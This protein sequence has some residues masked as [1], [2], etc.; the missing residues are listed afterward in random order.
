LNWRKNL[1][2][3]WFGCLISNSSY[4]ML[5]PFLPL[6]L[7]DLGASGAMIN[8]WS[9]FILSAT[10]FVSAMMAPY[11]GKRADRAG[12]RKMLLRAGFSLGSVYILG[13]F[14]SSPLELFG[15]RILQGF[16]AGFVPAALAIVSSSMPEERMGW[17]L[18]IMQAAIL[19]GTIIGPLIG[20]IL[21]H[22]FGIRLSFIVAGCIML[23]GTF[24]V[25]M[26]VTEPLAAGSKQTDSVANDVKVALNNRLFIWM[27]VLLSFS[28]MV[29]M[30]LQPITPLYIAE[31]Q[32]RIEGITLTSGLVFSLAGIAGVIGAP[33]WG[34]IGHKVGFAVIL[35]TIFTGAGIAVSLFSLTESIWSFSVLQFVFGFFIAGVIPTVNTITVLNSDSC[36]RGRAF[37][38]IMSANQVGSMIGPLIGGILSNWLGIKPTFLYTGIFLIFVGAVNWYTHFSKKNRGL[39]NRLLLNETNLSKYHGLQ[40]RETK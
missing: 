22:I 33:L 21:S 15:V 8:L 13:A 2:S 38:L 18:G 16:A 5:V 4:T 29:V 12:K 34:R 9:G 11:W 37:G 3:L 32:G 24:V 31:L 10:F 17:G 7:Y 6:Y 39:S 30:L 23:L 20:G 14:V 26:F 19:T 36:F 35:I 28:Q 25:K 1:W 40:R 27:L